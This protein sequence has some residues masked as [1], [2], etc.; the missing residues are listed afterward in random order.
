MGDT[1]AAPGTFSFLVPQGM[2]EEAIILVQVSDLAGNTA[3]D[4]SNAFT[5][6]DYTPPTVAINAPVPGDRF[7]IDGLMDIQWSADDNVDVT[8]VDIAYRE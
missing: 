3:A 2:T 5:V 8:S 7:D 6:T 1:L 4:S